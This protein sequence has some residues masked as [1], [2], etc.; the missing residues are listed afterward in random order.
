MA[1]SSTKLS[2]RVL[3]AFGCVYFFWGSTYVA[4]RFGVE[5]LPPFVLAS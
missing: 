4:I 2:G 1:S 3:F 5:A